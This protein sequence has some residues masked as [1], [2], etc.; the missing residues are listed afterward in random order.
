MNVNIDLDTVLKIIS[1]IKD[2][3]NTNNLALL[4]V[5][6]ALALIWKLSP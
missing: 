1:G 5:I 6:M 3:L 2:V 4:A